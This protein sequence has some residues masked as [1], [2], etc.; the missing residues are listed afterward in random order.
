MHLS[1]VLLQLLFVITQARVAAGLAAAAAVIGAV[2]VA[3]AR[4][5]RAA[6]PVTL[7]RRTIMRIVYAA[8]VRRN[9]LFQFFHVQ[10]YFRFHFLSSFLCL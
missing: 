8:C 7:A 9:P 6:A 5:A 10:Q 3:A 2:L 1:W 4:I